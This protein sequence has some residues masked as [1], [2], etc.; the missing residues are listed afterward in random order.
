M[1]HCSA[2]MSDRRW[3]AHYPPS[4]VAFPPIGLF[5]F[6][7]L[8]GSGYGSGGHVAAAAFLV[9]AGWLVARF[10]QS[11]WLFLAGLCVAQAGMVSMLPTFWALPTS[12]P[13][14]VA[15]LSRFDKGA[16]AP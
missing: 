3:P 12:P 14:G 7:M 13:D 5:I 15:G 4:I 11:P 16:H 8:D 10:A 6:S 1:Y 9:A 2:A